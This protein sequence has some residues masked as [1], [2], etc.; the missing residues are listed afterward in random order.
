MVLN[1]VSF[2]ENIGGTSSPVGH[3]VSLCNCDLPMYF[4]IRWC[5]S[6]RRPEFTKPRLQYS[7]IEPW[8]HDHRRAKTKCSEIS[9]PQNVPYGQPRDWTW[10]FTVKRKQLTSWAMTQPENLVMLFNVKF[11]DFIWCVVRCF[12]IQ[13]LQ[14]DDFEP[15]NQ[16]LNHLS[17][18]HKI[19][20][21]DT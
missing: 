12:G 14:M 2:F 10:S 6:Y 1:I 9:L 21:K 5:M 16:S 17:Q 8:P 4:T 11:Y 19:C 15:V 13:A 18:T 7:F 3:A 20:L